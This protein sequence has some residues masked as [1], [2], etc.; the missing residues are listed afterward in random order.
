M[1]NVESPRL[2]A[3]TVENSDAQGTLL[4]PACRPMGSPIREW[5]SRGRTKLALILLEW[6]V[7]LRF[8][9]QLAHQTSTSV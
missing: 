8:L 4:Q 6:T 9:S 7:R 1:G 3:F 5:P 2:E